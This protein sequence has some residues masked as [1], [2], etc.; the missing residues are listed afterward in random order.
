MIQ[1][2]IEYQRQGRHLTERTCAEYAKELRYFVRWASPLGLRWSTIQPAHLMSYQQACSRLRGTTTNKRLT[3]LRSFFGWMQQQGLRADNPAVTI[4]SVRTQPVQRGVTDIEAHDRYLVQPSTSRE[5]YD[6]KLL[7]AML[8]ETGCRVGEIVDLTFA[9]LKADEMTAEVD[10]KGGKPRQV[11]YGKRTAYMLQQH[12][13]GDQGRLFEAYGQ[14]HFR[15]ILEK[16]FDTADEHVNPHK[17]RHTYATRLYEA[18]CPLKDL[19]SLLGHSSQRT[20]E[21][22]LQISDEHRQK[23]YR[24]Y[25]Y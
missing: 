18:G 25:W 22:Y 24:R 10:G 13:D 7:F 17:L 20:T 3:A 21:R 9:D 8:A 15:Y 14:R 11:Y 2:Y 23:Q 12:P 5:E 19:A 6:A 4:S 1:D 16:Y